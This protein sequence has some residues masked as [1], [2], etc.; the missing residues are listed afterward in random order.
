MHSI[1]SSQLG[2]W[3]ANVLLCA[4]LTTL[5]YPLSQDLARNGGVT[6]KVTIEQCEQTVKITESY[7]ALGKTLGEPRVT[8]YPIQASAPSP[9]SSDTD[10]SVLNP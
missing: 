3:L 6:A 10:T 9:P 1:G 4:L 5:D 8:N 2:R 7:E